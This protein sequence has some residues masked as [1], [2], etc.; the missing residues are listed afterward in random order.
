MNG[1]LSIEYIIL[2]FLLHLSLCAFLKTLILSEG[3]LIGSLDYDLR[4]ANLFVLVQ[5]AS[6]PKGKDYIQGVKLIT[7]EHQREISTAKNGVLLRV[8]RSKM[9]QLAKKFMDV[10]ERIVKGSALRTADEAFITRTYKKV[11]L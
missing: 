8:V 3:K 4:S 7:Y 9:I 11:A 6:I 5:K 2:I 1:S 10:E